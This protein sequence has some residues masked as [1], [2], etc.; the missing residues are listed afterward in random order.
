MI[1]LVWGAL[2]DRRG[3]RIVFNASLLIWILAVLVLMKTTDLTLLT[4]V[5]MAIGTGVGGFMMAAQNL[6]LEFGSME[7]LPMRIAVANSAA[8]LTTV[9]GLI[10]GGVLAMSFSYPPVFWIAIL[11]KCAAIA[12]MIRY[13]GEPRT[14]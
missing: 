4:L 5:F 10:L 9:V 11:F 8:E 12:I 3:F 7:N 13:V 1:I 6:A 2:A 14:R